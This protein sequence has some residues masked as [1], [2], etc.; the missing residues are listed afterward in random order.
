MMDADT[1]VTEELLLHDEDFPNE[2][3]HMAHPD[4]YKNVPEFAPQFTYHS[5][6]GRHDRLIARVAWKLKDS[7]V[8][9]SFV[10][11]TGAPSHLYLSKEAMEVLDKA[12]RLLKDDRDTPYVEM[13]TRGDEKFPA[14]VEETP[15]NSLNFYHKHANILGLK[16]LRRLCLSLKGDTFCFNEEFVYF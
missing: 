11:D 12:G 6:Y 1:V 13:H 5:R 2:Y 9:M 16:S 7:M 14:T 15:K 10:C 4:D 3:V 8:P